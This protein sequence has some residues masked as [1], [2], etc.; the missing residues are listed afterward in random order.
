MP[1]QNVLP[2]FK[3]ADR[4]SALRAV[5][6]ALL[7]VRALDDMTCEK[8]S[9]L[10]D[11]SADTVRNASNEDAMLCFVAIARLVKMFP[12]ESAPIVAL[13][14]D[15]REPTPVERMARIERELAALKRE[16]L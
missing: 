3:A 10:L 16:A 11:C 1:D 12:D 15:D 5:S 4:E 13:W 2:I 8:L 9:K 7:K 6:R 14:S